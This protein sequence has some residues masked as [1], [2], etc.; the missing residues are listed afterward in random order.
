MDTKNVAGTHN[1]VLFNCKEKKMM[2]AT[3]KWMELE[4]V[5]LSLVSQAQKSKHHTVALTCRS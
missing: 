1:G 2:K 5:I 3:G 4:V